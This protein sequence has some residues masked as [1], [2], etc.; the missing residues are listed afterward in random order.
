[1]NAAPAER[2]E[3]YRESGNQRFSF[4]G[5]HFR[6]CAA[7]Q[8]HAADQL[9]IKVPHVQNAAAG[10]AHYGKGF[11]Q[12]LVQNDVC[13]FQ[14]LLIELSQPIEVSVGLVGNLGDAVLNL[15][16]ELFGFGAQLVVGKLADLRL[17]RIDRQDSRHHPLDLAFVLGAKNLA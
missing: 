3:I 10:L 6:N 2:V 16:A 13:D 7:V 12:N 5:F 15:L 1:M 14:S 9:H 8:H 17:E 11:L 4:A